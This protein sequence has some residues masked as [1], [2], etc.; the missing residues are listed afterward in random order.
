MLQACGWLHGGLVASYEKFVMD[1]DQLDE[2]NRV[3]HR[4]Q[5]DPDA[6]ALAARREVGPGGHFPGW[7]HTQAHFRAAL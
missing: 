7:A 5:T 1:A 2:R 3:A 6:Q 4:V